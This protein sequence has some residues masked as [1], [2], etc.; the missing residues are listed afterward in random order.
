MNIRKHKKYC[1]F[2]LMHQEQQFL[3]LHSKN[4]KEKFQENCEPWII[5]Q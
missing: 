1:G 2:L 4:K 5:A 3:S